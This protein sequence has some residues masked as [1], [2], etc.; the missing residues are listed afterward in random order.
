MV[1]VSDMDV[2]VHTTKTG[3]A[4]AAGCNRNSIHGGKTE[5]KGCVIVEAE[6]QTAKMG[7]GI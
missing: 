6:V 3:A 1:R 5:C 7:F 2:S 4:A